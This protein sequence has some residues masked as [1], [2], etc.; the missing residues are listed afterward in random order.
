M[1]ALP[2]AFE[3]VSGLHVYVFHVSTF[4][5]NN[6]CLKVLLLRYTH[7]QLKNSYDFLIDIPGLS[8][9]EIVSFFSYHHWCVLTM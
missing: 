2:S 5:Y 6:A 4:Q 1:E 9:L 3:A 8:S 7:V